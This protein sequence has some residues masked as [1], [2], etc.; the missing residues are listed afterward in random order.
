MSAVIPF[1]RSRT[2][3]ERLKHEAL[4]TV[5]SGAGPEVLQRRYG[6]VLAQWAQAVSWEQRGCPGTDPLGRE[7]WEAEFGGIGE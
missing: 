4:R 6:P 7:A 3:R 1:P 5:A 2:A